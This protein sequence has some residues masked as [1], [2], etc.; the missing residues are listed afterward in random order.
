M[1]LY[2]ASLN[3]LIHPVDQE[4]EEQFLVAKTVVSRVQGLHAEWQELIDQLDS[5][6]ARYQVKKL[7]TSADDPITRSAIVL[8]ECTER[9]EL[10]HASGKM[11]ISDVSK[12]CFGSKEIGIAKKWIADAREQ[13]KRVTD[14][15]QIV[16]HQY[17]ARLLEARSRIAKVQA[18]VQNTFWGSC[19]YA[20][21]AFKSQLDGST[22]ALTLTEAARMTDSAVLEKL[23]QLFAKLERQCQT[24][25]KER[26]DR[27]EAARKAEAERLQQEKERQRKLAEQEKERE[28]RERA[29]EA[30][31]QRM[32]AE[33]KRLREQEELARAKAEKAQRKQAERVA[34][35]V[36]H[37]ESLSQGSTIALNVI[38]LLAGLSLLYFVVSDFI[39]F[40]SAFIAAVLYALFGLAE[41]QGNLDKM[42]SENL[43]P[44]FWMSTQEKDAGYYLVFLM[45][46]MSIQLLGGLIYGLW[47]WMWP[48]SWTWVGV[49]FPHTWN[50]ALWYLLVAPMTLI[51]VMSIPFCFY[52]LRIVAYAR[53]L[54]KK[55]VPGG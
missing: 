27:E 19:E 43:S 26:A 17:D 8:N 53:Q 33:Q 44:H 30:E 1:Q 5:L 14:F 42:K 40:E 31:R 16:F 9:Y 20:L 32:A 2:A 23:D 28:R 18:D 49:I 34:Q 51:C 45:A 29:S 37:L 36:I 46:A 10:I 35:F 41:A 13:V 24:I 52:N 6:A 12:S 39:A 21:S 38:I 11:T 15:Y 7:L 48:V 4:L 3:N 25:E 55:Y 47:N 22:Q 50:H 54:L